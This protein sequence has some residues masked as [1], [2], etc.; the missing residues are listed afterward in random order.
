[1]VPKGAG[2]GSEKPKANTIEP[3]DM[4]IWVTCPLHMKGRSAR[5]MELLFD[6]VRW[7]THLVNMQPLAH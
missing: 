7:P 1:M 4:G 2:N 5:E 3:G 6:E